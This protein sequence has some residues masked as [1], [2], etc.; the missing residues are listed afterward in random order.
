MEVKQSNCSEKADLLL[1][2]R[3]ISPLGALTEDTVKYGAT[4][5]LAG[6]LKGKEGVI[7]LSLRLLLHVH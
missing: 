3:K 1:P 5:S 4:S 6:S 7:R 2:V